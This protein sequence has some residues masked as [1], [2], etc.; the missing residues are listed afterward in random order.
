MQ[1][2]S[3]DQD[4]Y[5]LTK[6]R[7]KSRRGSLWLGQTCNLRCK[8]CYYSS[9]V[10]DLTHPEHAFM[11]IDKAKKI[12]KTLVDNYNN[13]SVDIEG[14]EPTIYKD[15]YKL[16]RYCS[17]IGLKPTLITNAIALHN[18]NNCTKLKDANIADL[19]VSIHALG[20]TYDEIVQLKGAS[21]MQM[22]AIDNINEVKIP[23]RIN[24]VL[25]KE[26]LPQLIDI[27]QLA[28]KKRAR[29]VN[30]I[31]FNPFIDQNTG[32]RKLEA[33][34]R[35]SYI[36]EKLITV[37][38]YLNANSIEV[39]VR[40]L[41]MCIFEKNYRKFVQNFQQIIYDQ[42]EWE[43][44]GEVWSSARS[45]RLATEPLS[46]PIDFFEHIMSLRRTYFLDDIKE[47]S[48]ILKPFCQFTERLLNKIDRNKYSASNKM[49]VCIF[50]NATTGLQ[51]IEALNHNEKLKDK[52]EMSG[53]ISSQVYLK[54]DSL[55]G[56]PWKS[57]EWLAANPPD[58][59]IITSPSSNYQIYEILE[60]HE[61][62]DRCIS[63]FDNAVTNNK[64]E[65][66]FYLEE[67]GE[68]EGFDDMDYAYKEFR[69]LM[70]KFLHPYSKKEKCHNCS[71]TGICDGFH[72]DYAKIYGFDEGNSVN[73]DKTIYDPRYFISEQMKVAEEI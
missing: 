61:L 24:T 19:L 10:K 2:E 50:G 14:G 57:D 58:V 44:A 60:K 64:W 53:F 26:A 73:L 18:I 68:V 69:V 38:D 21:E 51:V 20:D 62:M 43:S 1:I 59:I 33:I 17:E 55:H 27:A 47:N 56:Y 46:K 54:G 66:R 48:G 9:K 28:V 37:I 65:K 39:N 34:P 67:L 52:W 35:Y 4:E 70:T 23:F 3:I 49:K 36:A 40:Y 22:K 45:Q 71:L 41:P 8:F 11:S 7:V 32:E 63:I 42:H 25:S 6:C 13:N 30:F 12:C 5:K 15:I 29:V 72:R 31:A 16:V